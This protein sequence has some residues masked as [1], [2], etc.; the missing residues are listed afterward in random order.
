MALGKYIGEEAVSIEINMIY[1]GGEDAIKWPVS[2]FHQH[3][4]ILIE[5]KEKKNLSAYCVNPGILF[6]HKVV[7]N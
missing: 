2:Y 3:L 1:T 6:S 5:K 4:F 7:F